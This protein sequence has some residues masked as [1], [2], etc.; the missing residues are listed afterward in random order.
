[1]FLVALSWSPD[2]IGCLSVSEMLAVFASCQETFLDEKKATL[3]GQDLFGLRR[4]LL[5]PNST[6]IA[7]FQWCFITFESI[8]GNSMNIDLIFKRGRFTQLCRLT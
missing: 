2:G 4:L 1:M 3:S 8:Q 5:S 7:A 6:D